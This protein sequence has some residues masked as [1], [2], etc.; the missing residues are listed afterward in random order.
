[1]R[2]RNNGIME[3]KE[4]TKPTEIIT[5]WQKEKV[6]VWWLV[7]FLN[8]PEN[9]LC[10]EQERSNTIEQDTGKTSGTL[11]SIPVTMFMTG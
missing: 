10:K 9:V 8:L 6:P 2:V 11:S 3:M 1:M 7:K 4:D 5:G